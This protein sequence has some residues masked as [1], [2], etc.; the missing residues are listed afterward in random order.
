MMYRVKQGRLDPV[1]LVLRIR[2]SDAAPDLTLATD[3][4]IEATDLTSG[5]METWATTITSQTTTLLV[6]VHPFETSDTA[7]L[8]RLKMKVFI[9]ITGA[10]NMVETESC[11]ELQVVEC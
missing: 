6:A 1:S 7:T 8:R 9:A 3:V 5:A 10:A 2:S 4:E 11:F